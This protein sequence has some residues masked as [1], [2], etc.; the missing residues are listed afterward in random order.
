MNADNVPV[1]AAMRVRIQLTRLPV[2]RPARMP[3]PAG[4]MHRHS[5]I[6]LLCENAETAFRLDDLHV[7]LSVTYCD[8]RRVISAI[9]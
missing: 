6:R 9:L 8:S 3:D 4:S 7:F 5:I 1:I 2:R